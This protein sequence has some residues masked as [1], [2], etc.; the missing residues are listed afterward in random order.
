MPR[1]PP[2]PGPA[3]CRQPL[4]PPSPWNSA[5]HPSAPRGTFT[6]R[7]AGHGGQRRKPGGAKPEGFRTTP[8]TFN[9]DSQSNGGCV[10]E[11]RAGGLGALPRASSGKS[12]VGTSPGTPGDSAVPRGTALPA[13]HCPTSPPRPGEVLPRGPSARFHPPPQGAAES[14]RG[15]AGCLPALWCCVKLRPASEQAGREQSCM[16][17]SQC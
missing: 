5:P 6:H 1:Q 4:M 3:L 7:G 8:R 11:G 9:K 10:S 14:P 12:S 15:D 13:S 2:S 16:R 17:A